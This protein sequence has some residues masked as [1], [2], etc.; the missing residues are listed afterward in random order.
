MLKTLLTFLPLTISQN[1]ATSAGSNSGSTP[2][3]KFQYR[4]SFKGP[5]LTQTNGQVPFWTHYGHAI[6][7]EEQVRLTPSLRSRSGSIWSKFETEF[8]AWE[9]EIWIKVSGKSRIGA[10]GL[11]IWYTETA[12]S[13]GKVF[14]GND[15][16]NG[17]MLALDSFDNNALGDNPIVALMLN[18]GTKSYDHQNDGKDQIV[19]SCRR[20]YRNKVY[21]VKIK[22]VYRNNQLLIMYDQGLT[23][24]EDYEVCARVVDVTLPKKGFFGASAATGG[25]ADDHDILKFMTYSLHEPSAEN[26]EESKVSA[27]QQEAFRKQKEELAKIKEENDKDAKQQEEQLMDQSEIEIK[28]IYE[29]TNSIH[30]HVQESGEVMQSVKNLLQAT[31]GKVVGSN[32]GGASQF[33]VNTIKNTVL[34]HTRLLNEMKTT[35][36]TMNIHIGQKLGPGGGAVGTASAGLN[37]QQ[38]NMIATTKTNTDALVRQI[39]DLQSQIRNMKQNSN[40]DY[41][42]QN[43]PDVSCATSGTLFVFTI[44]QC[45]VIVGIMTFIK[46][47]EH[48]AKKYF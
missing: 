34:E 6:A 14:G 3:K 35:I 36:S 11:A 47:K 40:S 24:F 44:I 39:T 38:N 41:Q 45:V 28:K 9:I 7:S 48:Q 26:F 37:A 43:C 19:A 5:Q 18:D 22:I 32:Q 23:D 16:W 46:S 21:P 15:G 27:A 33:D 13:I 10:D 2:H 30:K 17:M 29:V 1:A 25:L 42:F 20:D 8:D 31:A 4:Y 12:G